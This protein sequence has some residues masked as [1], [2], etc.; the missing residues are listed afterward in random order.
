[1]RNDE[2][3]LMVHKKTYHIIDQI[4]HLLKDLRERDVDIEDV[5]EY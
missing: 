3:N 4:E 1:M 5:Y 2:L